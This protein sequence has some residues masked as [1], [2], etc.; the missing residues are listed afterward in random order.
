MRKWVAR[1]LA[2]LVVFVT[3]W[4]GL[5]TLLARYQEEHTRRGWAETVRSMDEFER[6]HPRTTA[7]DAALAVASKARALGVELPFSPDGT[8]ASQLGPLHGLFV[9]LLQFVSAQ[10]SRVNDLE[11]VEDTPPDLAQFLEHY[12]S[13]LESLEDEIL[14]SPELVWTRE[15]TAMDTHFVGLRELVTLLRL[16]ALVKT[17]KGNGPGA[18]RALEAGWKLNSA[19]RDDPLVIDQLI[20]MAV[21]GDLLLAVRYLASPS[22][23]WRTRVMD[24]DYRRSV[25][26]SF[27]GEVLFASEMMRRQRE[28]R[29]QAGSWPRLAVWLEG[30]YDRLC[31]AGYS[32]LMRRAILGLRSSKNPCAADTSSSVFQSL[33]IPRWN[34]VAEEALPSLL[35]TFDHATNF[36]ILQDLT[37]RLLEARHEPGQAHW[38]QEGGFD[39]SVCEDL[40]WKVEHRPDGAVT[41]SPSR[42]LSWSPGNLTIER[43]GRRAA[44]SGVVA[45]GH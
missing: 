10:I 1:G 9:P 23:V 39:S 32:D 26:V 34:V 27:Q 45:A 28:E 13:T 19:Y 15:P 11:T 37:N 33:Q 3:L 17:R 5:G 40:K 2:V 8:P 20:A 21:D 44:R 24:H 41:V 22:A 42:P 35:A 31:L 30:P 16:D 36:S 25:L 12:S 18:D 43:S 14:K 38:L 29:V 4:L 6:Q 7:N